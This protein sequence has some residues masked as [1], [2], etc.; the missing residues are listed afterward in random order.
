MKG[1]WVEQK[2]GEQGCVRLH[3]TACEA[4]KGCSLIYVDPM[5]S[6]EGR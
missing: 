6:G 3:G 1:L 5:M 2:Q 4:G